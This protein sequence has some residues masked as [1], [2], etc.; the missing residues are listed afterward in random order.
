MSRPPGPRAP[1]PPESGGYTHAW[2]QVVHT[3]SMHILFISLSMFSLYCVFVPEQLPTEAC[4]HWQP[5]ASIIILKLKPYTSRTLSCV[6]LLLFNK[7]LDLFIIMSN[8][9]SEHTAYS[10]SN[11]LH[12]TQPPSFFFYKPTSSTMQC[13]ERPI[14]ARPNLHPIIIISHPLHLNTA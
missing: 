12:K 5:T 6:H 2:F 4:P 8:G 7:S 3:G 14:Y 1:P 11:D 13:N 10:R 9:G